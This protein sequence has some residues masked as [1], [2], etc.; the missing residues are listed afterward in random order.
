MMLRRMRAR[1][2]PVDAVGIQS[3]LSAGPAGAGGAEARFEYGAGLMRFVGNLRELG[4]QVFVTEMDVNDRALPAAVEERDERVAE[5][6]GQ[7]LK[8][9]LADRAVTAVMM[10]GVTDR[11]T[12]LNHED[13]R[14][15][16]VAERPLLFDAEGKG[17][18]AFFTTRNSFDGRRVRPDG[19]VRAGL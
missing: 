7:Y 15:D 9:V 16:H 11:D 10:W 18:Q 4:L 1:Q 12:W 3:H 8:L 17:K 2:V 14:A 19:D 6:Y 5:V 13:A